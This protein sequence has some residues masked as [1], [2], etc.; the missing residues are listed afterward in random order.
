MSTA[1]LR[2][3]REK[4]RFRLTGLSRV[5]AWRLEREGRFPKRIQ[6]GS[7]SVGWIASELDAWIAAKAKARD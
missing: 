5:Q 6:L 3:L 4:D 7:N 2:V 1:E